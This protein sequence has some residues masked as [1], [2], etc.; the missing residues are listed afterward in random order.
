LDLGQELEQRVPSVQFVTAIG[1]DHEDVVEPAGPEQRD[2][3]RPRRLVGPVKVLD[4]DDDR[5]SG[6]HV[7]E[8]RLE[9]TVEARRPPGQRRRL[10]VEGALDERCQLRM[11]GDSERG[12]HGYQFGDYLR[13]R[14]QRPDLAAVLEASPAHRV[15]RTRPSVVEQLVEEAAL[16]D[17]G[18]ARYEQQRNSMRRVARQQRVDGQSSSPDLLVTTDHPVARG[19]SVHRFHHR[20]HIVIDGPVDRI[21]SVT[22]DGREVPQMH[23]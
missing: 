10:S 12:R 18:L 3:Q 4:G 20:T 21:G 6:R 9:E 15:H 8:Q 16:T 14:A 13:D 2:Q 23:I 17:P 1:A 22:S 5:P 11:D 19:P 7:A